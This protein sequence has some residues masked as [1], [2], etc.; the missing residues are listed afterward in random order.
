MPEEDRK[1]CK[2][3]VFDIDR[4]LDIEKRAADVEWMSEF[5]GYEKAAKVSNW[6]LTGK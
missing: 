3:Q 2:C 5:F 1:Y 6:L 4:L